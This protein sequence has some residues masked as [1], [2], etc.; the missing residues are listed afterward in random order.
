M[1]VAIVS[2]NSLGLSLSS[3]ATGQ[4]GMTGSAALGR[5]GQQI[6]VNSAN[7][8]L[9]LQRQ[10]DRL[11]STGLDVFAVRTYNSQGM[12]DGDGNNDN[13]RIGF[14]RSVDS[15]TGTL[16]TTSS[17]ITRTDADGA[18]AIYRWDSNTN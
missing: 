16:N 11:L 9:V 15:L 13:W 8:N 12:F 3:F 4:N 6:Y 10:D 14:F 17:A 2:G 7:G 1:M 18:R 5:N